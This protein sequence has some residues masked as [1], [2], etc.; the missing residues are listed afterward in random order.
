MAVDLVNGGLRGKTENTIFL[1]LFKRLHLCRQRW[2][3]VLPWHSKP[4]QITPTNESHLWRSGNKGC[5][6]GVSRAQVLVT[7]WRNKKDSQFDDFTDT[8]NIF[9]R[10]VSFCHYN[11]TP[12]IASS[13]REKHWSC[14]SAERCSPGLRNLITLGLCWGSSRMQACVRADCSTRQRHRDLPTDPTSY[15][16]ILPPP[17]STGDHTF[18]TWTSSGDAQHPNHRPSLRSNGFS[19]T[20]CT[21]SQTD[22]WGMAAICT[23][24]KERPPLPLHRQY[25]WFHNPHQRL[26]SCSPELLLVIATI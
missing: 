4:W 14:L 1:H 21:C 15:W 25:S 16:E 11:K 13:W 20:V 9:T 17:S 23:C 6:M 3:W 10:Q 22:G 19:L 24:G 18:K 8:S 26:G 5:D 12:Q 2:L 7:L